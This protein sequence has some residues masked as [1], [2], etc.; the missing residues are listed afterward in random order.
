M[1]DELPTEEMLHASPAQVNP[2]LGLA[3]SPPVF[4]PLWIEGGQIADMSW[5]HTYPTGQ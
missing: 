3:P 5:R 1:S 2:D 4:V